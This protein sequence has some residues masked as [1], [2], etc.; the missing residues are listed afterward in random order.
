MVARV[1]EQH[2]GHG[3]PVGPGSRLLSVNGVLVEALGGGRGPGGAVP[4]SCGATGV[5]AA[6]VSGG[7][8]MG[9]LYLLHHRRRSCACLSFLMRILDGCI[10]TATA[11]AS[12]TLCFANARCTAHKK[13]P[14][15]KVHNNVLAWSNEHP[16]PSSI[17]FRCDFIAENRTCALKC[18]ID[19]IPT[20]PTWC[21]HDHPCA[22]IA[23]VIALLP[24]HGC[25]RW[26]P[27][28]AARPQDRVWGR[29]RHGG[30]P[31]RWPAGD[32]QPPRQQLECLRP[33]TQ[34]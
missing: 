16:L 8:V 20:Y 32:L 24:S 23:D 27:G 15:H 25:G 29:I 30:V 34:Q 31:C 4:V 6:G 18:C 11:M 9:M 12:D 19:K 22:P 17:N 26:D 5:P 28:A 14:N 2:W 3:C 10:V 33:A 21:Q 7:G 13:N 1:A